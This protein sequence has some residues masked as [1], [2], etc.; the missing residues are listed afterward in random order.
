MS[1]AL[2]SFHLLASVG[3][4]SL[5]ACG[6]S[7][8]PAST[9]DGSPAP[10][11]D[12]TPAATSDAPTLAADV[13]QVTRADQALPR[14]FIP[15]FRDCRAPLPGA[16]S[17]N[18]KVCTQV[19][20]PGATEAGKY[21]P[22][23]ASC[24][25]I[26]TQR[27]Y[28]AADPAGVSR[29]DDP[30]LQDAAFVKELAWVT[31]QA[32]A[33]ACTC[34]HDSKQAKDGPSQWAIDAGPIWTDTASDA[35]IA[36]FAGLADSSIFGAFDPAQ[37]N[38]FQRALTGLP[39]DD[40]PRMRAFFVAELERRGISAEKAA[41]FPPFGGPLYSNMHAAPAACAKG[42]GIDA[43]GLV[44]W[45]ASTKARYVY[46]LEA[47]AQNPGVPPNFDRP[48]GT[49][50]RLD[51]LASQSALASGVRYGT[52]PP[53]SFQSIPAAGRASALEPGKTYHLYAL[54]DVAVVATNC[55]FTYGGK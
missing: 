7:A 52:T 31:E 33:T 18:G 4:A 55:L 12:G 43:N 26:R 14:T 47:G 23:Y 34:C 51:V 25:V 10:G 22:D 13:E 1:F 32:R 17:A 37:N 40:G 30:R 29:A 49:L 54:R 9:S 16:T 36:L 39:S 35:A 41:S 8:T 6:S 15:P 3:V 21:Y 50:W 20:L 45:D 27:P 46:V 48:A 19:G 24:D 2:R 38:G 42:E 11:A 53:G 5:V 44:T 28:W